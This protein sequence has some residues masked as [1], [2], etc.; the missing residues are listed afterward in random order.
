[1][2]GV[3]KVLVVEDDRPIREMIVAALAEAGYAVAVARNGAEGL[4]RCREFVP[5]LVAR[6]RDR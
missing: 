1:M 2:A 4:D 5:D 6:G 3:R